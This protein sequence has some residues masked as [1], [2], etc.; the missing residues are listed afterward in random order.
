MTQ[1]RSGFTLIEVSIVLVIVGLLAGGILLGQEL[2]EAAGVRSSV[3]KLGSFSTATNTFRTKY[4]CLPGDCSQAARFGLVARNGGAGCGNGDGYVASWY[5]TEGNLLD[6]ND[7]NAFQACSGQGGDESML[8]FID[9]ATAGLL[10]GPIVLAD[11][12]S[13]AIDSIMP[14]LPTDN[15]FVIAANGGEGNRSPSRFGY[16]IIGYPTGTALWSAHAG[17]QG[18]K[19]LRTRSALAIDMKM[20]D[21][22]PLRGSVYTLSELPSYNGGVPSRGALAGCSN[23]GGTYDIAAEA[24]NDCILKIRGQ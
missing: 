13:A 8:F 22:N 1:A 11:P 23:G 18:F 5:V 7:F 4:N 3:A 14:R 21:G 19:P 6:I 20:D 24:G 16:T 9:L 12:S 2:I 10:E 17:G 15:A